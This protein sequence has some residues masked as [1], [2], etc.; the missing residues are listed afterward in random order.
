MHLRAQSMADKDSNYNKHTLDA[1]RLRD[2]L[3]QQGYLFA[4]LDSPSMSAAKPCVKDWTLGKKYGQL[5]LCVVVDRRDTM[6]I[7]IRKNKWSDVQSHLDAILNSKLK[8]GYLKAYYS[9]DTI[10]VL[11]NNCTLWYHLNRKNKYKIDSVRILHAGNAANIRFVENYMRRYYKSKVDFDWKSVV[12][13]LRYFEFLDIE[14]NPDFM[15]LDSSAILNIYL[16]ERKMNQINA[17]LG[18]LSNAY[19]SNEVNLTGDVKLGFVNIL[20]RGISLQLNWQKNLDNSQFLYSKINIPFLLNTKI[21]GLAHFNIEKFDTSYLRVQYQIGLNYAVQSNQHVSFFYRKN[22]STITGFNS[23]ELMNG[24]LPR[25]LDFVTNE[26]G[27]GYSIFRVNRPLFPRSGWSLDCNFFTGNKSIDIN[28]KIANL[29]DGNGNSLA[30]LYDSILLSQSTYSFMLDMVR[31]TPIGSSWV[32]KSRFDAKVWIAPSISTGE[33]FYIGGNKLPRGFD[34]NSL[35][36]PWYATMSHELQYY[37]SE[38]FYSNIFVDVTVLKNSL[39]NQIDKPL[40]LGAGIAL[41]T[42]ENI[43]SIQFGTGFQNKIGQSPN[44]IKVHLNYV[45]VF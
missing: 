7:K 42:G 32:V 9:Y 36:V 6:T 45:N 13:Q 30:Q 20:R 16:K 27:V 34:D 14:K 29:K 24:R 18:I 33:M 15:I 19:N 26:I 1:I 17:I 25:H 4:S 37:L 41:R 12:N 31:Y 43:F 5:Q 2:K 22:S 35:V 28:S 10:S 39:N 40:G 23:L 38:Y 21:G 3:L 8:E 11:N 44:S